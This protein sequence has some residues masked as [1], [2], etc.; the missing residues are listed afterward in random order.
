MKKY[1]A[2]VQRNRLVFPRWPVLHLSRLAASFHN[3]QMICRR[4][5][6]MSERRNLHPSSLTTNSMMTLVRERTTRSPQTKPTMR[7]KMMM[8]RMVT[9]MPMLSLTSVIIKRSALVWALESVVD[10]VLSDETKK[11]RFHRSVVWT[12]QLRLWRSRWLHQ[13][14]A[15]C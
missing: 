9:S 11:I 7:M 8:T 14:S 4:V 13:L 3:S 1:G 12:N 15:A 2:Q 6:T 5:S 10:L